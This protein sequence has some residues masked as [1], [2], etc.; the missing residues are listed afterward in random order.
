MT[1]PAESSFKT[2]LNISIRMKDIRCFA[3]K[4]IPMT[5]ARTKSW[6]SYNRFCGQLA[7]HKH[8]YRHLVKAAV[9]SVSSVLFTP[10][11]FGVQGF[12]F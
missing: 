1:G 3:A 11:A 12:T 8:I 9:K 6:I 10:S 5:M 4:A 2:S 7:P